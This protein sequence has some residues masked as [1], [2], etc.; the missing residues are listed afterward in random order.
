M[1]A[2]VTDE[3]A[4]KNADAPRGTIGT[5]GAALL[6]WQGLGSRHSLH[7][8]HCWPRLCVELVAAVLLL[9]LSVGGVVP[10][11]DVHGENRDDI[12]SHWDLTLVGTAVAAAD[13]RQAGAGDGTGAD[14]LLILQRV[15]PGSDV[16]GKNRDDFAS[17]C[18]CIPPAQY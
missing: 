18:N 14:V 11:S 1:W 17:H 10:G 4:V 9:L 5:A 6:G 12:A 16:H 13:A 2:V 15:V 7:G 8:T 3:V